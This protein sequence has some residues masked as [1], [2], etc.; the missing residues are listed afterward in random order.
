METI[1]LDLIPRGKMPSLHASQYDEG[2][3][4][5]IDLT[6]NRA[7][8][9]LDGTETI[10]LTVRK[11]DN[12]LV[13]MDIA[14]TFANQSYIEFVT[15]EQMNACAGFNVGEI[16]LEENGDRIGSLNFYLLVEQ[17]PD[18]GGLT[19]Q[20]EINNLDRQI[21]DYLDKTL[22]GQIEEV[23]DP[24]VRELVPTVVGD[25]YPTKAEMNE[26]LAD[27]IDT[28]DAEVL[29][30]NKYEKKA[31]KK[32]K[33]I[34]SI[35]TEESVVLGANWS[36]TIA[37]GFSHSSGSTEPLEFNIPTTNNKPYL[38][39][40]NSTGNNNANLFVKI[41]NSAQVDVYDG[42]N[43]ANIGIVADGGKLSIIPL[44][45]FSGTI[46][47]LKLREISDEGS[48]EV[49]LNIKSVTT[50]NESDG[51]TGYWNTVIG[52]ENFG[53]NENGSRNIVIGNNSLYFHKSGARNVAIGTYALAHVTKADRNVAIGADAMINQTEG[54]DNVA[55]GVNALCYGGNNK[56]NV[57]I[58]SGALNSASSNTA[59]VQ[60][61][62]AI[63][64]NAGAYTTGN[65]NVA[66]GHQAGYRNRTGTGN[67]IVGAS[68]LGT[69]GGNNNTFIGS[70]IFSN[71]SLADSIGLG[72]SATPTKSNQMMLG[73][74]AITEV[75]MCGN[76]KINFNQDG[77]VTWEPLT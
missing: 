6:E 25:N 31:T 60:E 41:G 5:H 46:T 20:S 50:T 55:V 33:V 71:S 22:P 18:E 19:S 70:L 30:S 68:A 42:T 34:S 74:S 2:R 39:S 7:P 49:T 8:Y 66:I 69:N 75:V 16:V 24:I 4:Y 43:S 1:K 37:G 77:T 3:S 63:G 14:N 51:L 36:G 67:T 10:S 56:N 52:F 35:L 40:F 53:N 62:I 61:N 17:A 29:V 59:N 15:T 48:E 54:E 32:L 38:I 13:T 21:E 12:T 45:S 58:G 26:A 44:T 27:K 65:Q 76:K 47:N 73:S 64:K 57:A 9:T 28:E 11:C 23:A 72:R